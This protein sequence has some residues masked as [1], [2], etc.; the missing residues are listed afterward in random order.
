MK[1]KPA[2][3]STPS[4]IIP[5]SYNSKE[6]RIINDAYGNPWWVAKDVCIVLGH[7]NHK[8]AVIGLDDDEVRKVYLADALNRE[9]ENITV[10]E[11]G[12][13]TLII[14][15]NKPEAKKFRKWVTSE[16]LPQIRRTGQYSAINEPRPEQLSG[17]KQGLL[18]GIK[19]TDTLHRYHLSRVDLARIFN[20]RELG[21]SQVET[22]RIMGFSAEKLQLIER[23]L[24]SIGIDVPKAANGSARQAVL[25]RNL[26]RAIGLA[27]P[28]QKSLPRP[29]GSSAESGNTGLKQLAAVKNRPDRKKPSG[30]SKKKLA[31]PRVSDNECRCISDL[32]NQGLGVSAI[33]KAVGRNNE[34][35]RRIL[36]KLTAG[37]GSGAGA[38]RTPVVNPRMIDLSD[39]IEPGEEGFSG[40][41]W[42][43]P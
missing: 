29:V 23:D 17:F 30:K 38:I 40:A 8:V 24:A 27:G 32:F 20:F 22:A 13:Y 15:S 33:G 4:S 37:G 12:L 39:V 16:V 3:K 41:S 18:R 19:F 5:F 6:I 35:V 36:D 34:T 2:V 25:L 26:N 7:S 31:R 11:S 9:Q 21:L 10:S 28:D 42:R 14:R 43:R 1:K